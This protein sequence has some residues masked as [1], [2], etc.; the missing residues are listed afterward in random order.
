MADRFAIRP[1]RL[2]LSVHDIWKGE[3]AVVEKERLPSL[4]L[5]D[6]KEWAIRLNRMERGG[7]RGPNPPPLDGDPL[8][9]YICSK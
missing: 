5:D 6:A 2:G 7:D 9:F 1:D 4:R 3:T 8:M